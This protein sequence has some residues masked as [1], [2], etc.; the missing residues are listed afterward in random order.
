MDYT[1]GFSIGASAVQGGLLD[2]N[3]SISYPFFVNVTIS[4]A[5][6]VSIMSGFNI[7]FERVIQMGAECPFVQLQ[8]Y[9]NVSKIQGSAPIVPTFGLLC[10]R[11]QYLQVFSIKQV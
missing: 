1:G 2:F 3:Y 5:P 9:Y 10:Q 8:D 4:Q 11:D 7:T 6:Q